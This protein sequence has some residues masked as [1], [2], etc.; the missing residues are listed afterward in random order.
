MLDEVLLNKIRK[1]SLKADLPFFPL[2]VMILLYFRMYVQDPCLHTY[3]RTG[4]GDTEIPACVV[5]ENACL[6]NFQYS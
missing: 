6:Q 5:G 1:M 4:W 2:V 3:V